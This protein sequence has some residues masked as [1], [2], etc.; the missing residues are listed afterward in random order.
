[1]LCNSL[2]GVGNDIFKMYSRKY[3]PE[4]D[5]KYDKP[6]LVI[7]DWDNKA[8]YLRILS[9]LKH[10]TRVIF[11]ST[12]TNISLEKNHELLYNIKVFVSN[13]DDIPGFKPCHS[14][15]R[16][17][18]LN[19]QYLK[20]LNLEQ[21]TRLID[22]FICKKI[23]IYE[24]PLDEYNRG[25]IITSINYDLDKLY[26]STRGMHKTSHIEKLHKE[27]STSAECYFGTKTIDEPDLIPYADIGFKNVVFGENDID[28]KKSR[29]ILVD[30]LDEYFDL[31]NVMDNAI[32]K[33]LYSFG[34]YNIVA[35]DRDDEKHIFDESRK[36]A[37]SKQQ[38][39]TREM[40]FIDNSSYISCC[41]DNLIFDMG[42][43]QGTT[44]EL[45]PYVTF[46]DP[47]LKELY[48]GKYP[49]VEL[50]VGK[51]KVDYSNIKVM[52]TPSFSAGQMYAITGNKK[53]QNSLSD[54][55]EQWYNGHLYGKNRSL[56]VSN[57]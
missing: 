51:F 17:D 40:L 50:D 20:Y 12:N 32:C 14:S 49:I 8:P 25:A 26:D 30:F 18:I 54:D 11:S 57:E 21:R 47:K 36:Y 42:L 31:T 9:I 46:V 7:D 28:R 19:I 33:K 10:H 29:V 3:I 35:V 56:C 22:W 5:E 6:I 15:L 2:C 53:Y 41:V 45:T 16:Y 27:C 39:L 23:D 4:Y 44:Q 13:T 34:R 37:L 52:D 38:C 43:Y 55:T 1:M 48:K 24:K